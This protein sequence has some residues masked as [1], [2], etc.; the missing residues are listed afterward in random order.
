MLIPNFLLGVGHVEVHFGGK[1]GEYTA[2]LNFHRWEML[3]ALPRIRYI[4]EVL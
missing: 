2:H 1:I 3:G 4:K